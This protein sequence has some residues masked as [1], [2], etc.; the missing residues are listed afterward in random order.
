VSGR[1]R[2]SSRNQNRG[3]SSAEFWGNPAANEADAPRIAKPD[4][5]TP[6][7]S[8]L[9]SPPLPGRETIAQHYFTTVYDKAAQMAA[10]LAATVDLLATEDE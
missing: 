4:D 3:S 7:I 6:L 1:R 8:S 10:A 2:R 9:G 5:V